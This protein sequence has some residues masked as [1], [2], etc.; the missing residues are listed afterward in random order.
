MTHVT[1]NFF[2]FFFFLLL[3]CFL[4][5]KTS[6]VPVIPGNSSVW[7]FHEFLSMEK[8]GAVPV[9]HK[10]GFMVGYVFQQVIIQEQNRRKRGQNLMVQPNDNSRPNSS[11]RRN[12]EENR[13]LVGPST[14]K[15]RTQN[16]GEYNTHT[17]THTHTHIYIQDRKEHTVLFCLIESC[18]CQY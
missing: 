15:P 11:S 1:F 8:R 7:N 17:H 2:F 18:A 14:P 13:P 3:N 4:Q 5:K 16:Y 12:L 9:T 6:A 10:N